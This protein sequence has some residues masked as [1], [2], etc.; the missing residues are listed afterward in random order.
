METIEKQDSEFCPICTRLHTEE[1][2][3][4]LRIARAMDNPTSFEHLKELTYAD[5]KWIRTHSELHVITILEEHIA[6]IM[7]K[8]IDD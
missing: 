2:P 7:F 8:E 1:E 6:N 4:P 5:S 3:C